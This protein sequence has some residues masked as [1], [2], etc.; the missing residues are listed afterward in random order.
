MNTKALHHFHIPVL[1]LAYSIDTPLKVARFG[2][3]SAIS[4]MDDQLVEDVRKYY[5]GEYGSPYVAIGSSEDDHRAKRITAYLNLVNTIVTEQVM[6]LRMLPFTE[7]SE[8]MKYFELLPGSSSVRESFC[9]MKSMPDGA[10]KKQLQEQL[11]QAIIPGSIDVNIMSKVDKTNFGA[12]GSELPKEYADAHAA[13]RGYANS[14]LCSSLIFSA[15]YNPSLY[16]YATQFPDFYPDAAGCLKKKIILKVSDF[17]SALVQ[18]KIF[19]KKGLWVSELR[20]ESGLN[21]GGHAFA[22]EG[23]LLGPILEE[24]KNKKA[25]LSSELFDLCQAALLQKNTYPFPHKPTLNITAQGGIGTANENQFLLEYYALDGT[26]WGSPF[27]LVPEATH[28]DTDT[29]NDLATARQEDYYLSEASPLGI[30]FNNFR[31]SSAEK[32][33]LERIAKNRPGSPCHKQFLVS[34]TEFTTSPICTASRKYQYFKLR[35]LEE[36]GLPDDQYKTAFKAITEKDCL[37]EG[38]GVSIRLNNHIPL[39]HSL[40]A[41]TICPGPNLAYFSGIFSLQQMTDHIYG[42]TNL[43]NTLYRPNMFINELHLYLDHLRKKITTC[44]D[45][46]VKQQKSLATFKSN[47]LAGIDYY[48]TLVPHLKKENDNYINLW[49]EELHKAQIAIE[50][51]VIPL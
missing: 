4:I 5:C 37:C 29:L 1:G 20:I 30:P 19:A 45:M 34:D 27:L 49:K 32:Q 3:A 48:K 44:T 39:S 22:T 42:R 15:G 50:S 25:A 14:E 28:V 8:I 31:K 17:R 11:R 23:I 24:F 10:T 9:I 33:R 43:L 47:L 2:I 18:G 12:N 36:K 6:Q 41:V 16:A 51:L 13:L 46:T 26:G 21:C 35:Q 38:L 7:G 40:S